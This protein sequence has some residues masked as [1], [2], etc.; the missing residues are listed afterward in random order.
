MTTCTV[1]G[2]SHAYDV[3]EGYSVSPRQQYAL[4]MNIFGSEE[5]DGLISMTWHCGR[6]RIMHVSLSIVHQLRCGRGL[7]GLAPECWCMR[8][9][10]APGL[11]VSA[12]CFL[13]RIRN[14]G[15]FQKRGFYFSSGNVVLILMMLP[16]CMHWTL[17]LEKLICKVQ[18]KQLKPTCDA[19]A[20]LKRIRI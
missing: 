18:R 12:A 3:F 19:R 8:F 5:G 11:I 16:R 4:V 13:I 14:R 9:T 15:S 20:I 1:A 6:P 17:T 7:I 10:I 2:M